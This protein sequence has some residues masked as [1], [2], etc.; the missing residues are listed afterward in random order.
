[1]TNYDIPVLCEYLQFGFPLNVNYQVFRFNSVKNHPSA[2]REPEVDNYFYKEV[3]F[4]TIVDPL[5]YL[6]RVIVDISWPICGSVNDNVPD[7]VLIGC[8]LTLDT[9]QLI[10]LWKKFQNWVPQLSFIKWT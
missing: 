9:P 8:L 2:L 10:T 5:Y 6:P 4:K 3:Y 1:M 7:N